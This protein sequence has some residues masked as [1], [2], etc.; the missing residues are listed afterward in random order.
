MWNNFA[1]SAEAIL[2]R[3]ILKRVCKFLLKKKL[4]Q[5]LIGEIDLDQLDVQIAAGTLELT[6]LALNVDFVNQKFGS[7]SLSGAA[8][9]LKCSRIVDMK[10]SW[11]LG[12][13]E[14]GQTSAFRVHEGSIRSLIIK[15]PWNGRGC[16]VEVEELEIVLS[17]CCN[18]GLSNVAGNHDMSGDSHMDHALGKDEHDT[19]YKSS[20]ASVNVHEGVKAVAKL[21]KWLLT[22]FHIRIKNVIVAFDACVE[23]DEEKEVS[24]E[25]LILRITEIECGTCISDD[26]NSTEGTKTEDF[27]GISHLTNFLKF[28][29]ANVELLQMNGVSAENTASGSRF[30]SISKPLLTGE[31]GGFSGSLKLVIP[32]KNGSLDIRKV[33]AEVSIDPLSA[34][35]RPRTLEW[36]LDTW[37]MLEKRKNERIDSVY[38][39]AADTAFCGATYYCYSSALPT[40]MLAAEGLI[41]GEESS[42]ESSVPFSEP[43]MNDVLL[44][45]SRLISD[46]MPSFVGNCGTEGIEDADLGSSVDQFFECFDGMRSFHSALGNSGMWGWTSTVFSAIT[47][48][49]N[50][51]SGSL[52]ISTEQQHVQ[53]NIKITF[54]GV[55]MILSFLDEDQL[56]LHGPPS[57]QVATDANIHHLV[58]SCEDIV[59]SVQVYPHEWKLEA[60]VKHIVLDDY[61]SQED[62]IDFDVCWREK[63]VSTQTLLIEG[64]QDRVLSA[65]PSSSC[66]PGTSN[67]DVSDTSSAAETPS[68][69]LTAETCV[70]RSDIIKA[71][72]FQTSGA[73]MF[74]MS[75]KSSDGGSAGQGSFSLK[76]PAFTFWLNFDLIKV[77][78]DFSRKLGNS[79]GTSNEGTGLLSKATEQK[80]DSSSHCDAIRDQQNHAASTSRTGS[81]H[82]NVYLPHAR[83][84]LCFP[85]KNTGGFKS[86]YSCDQFVA[87]DFS[88]PPN[89]KKSKGEGPALIQED[90]SVKKDYPFISHSL[91]L[92]VVNLDIYLITRASDDCDSPPELSAQRF[93]T[94]KI[95]SVQSGPDWVRLIRMLWQDNAVTGAWVFESAKL[96]ATSDEP[97]NKRSSTT[98]GY[99]FASVST[100]KDLEDLSSQRQREMIYS[101]KF[102]LHVCLSFT[103]VRLSRSQYLCF[104][105]LLNE[106]VDALSAVGSDAHC[107][108][109]GTAVNQTSIFLQCGSVEIQIE[110]DQDD[111]PTSSLQRELPGS[112]YKLRLEIQNLSLLSVSDIGAVNAASFLWISHSEGK[113]WGSISSLGDQDLI[114]ISCS[115]S[116]SGRGNGEGSNVLSCRP[117]GSD[118][119]HLWDPQ[120]LRNCMSITVNCGTIV[121][122]GG[123]LDWLD[124]IST[125][126]SLP[127][128][129]I[130]EGTNCNSQEGDPQEASFVLKFIDAALSYEPY[131]KN[132]E[133]LSSKSGCSVSFYEDLCEPY[134]ACLLAASYLTLSNTTTADTI[135]N[136]YSIRFQDLGLL[137]HAVSKDEGVLVDYSVD[138]L[139]ELGY[140]KVAGEALID[141]VL[142]IKCE[143][144]ISWELTCSESHIVLSTCHDTAFGLIRLA[145]QIQQLFAPDIKDSIVHLQNRWISLQQVQGKDDHKGDSGTSNDCSPLEC[146]AQQPSPDSK[147]KSGLFGLMDEISEYAFKFDGKGASSFDGSGPS[148]SVGGNL[149]DEGPISTAACSGDVLEG[150]SASN[151][152]KAEFIEGY[153][154][155]G[156]RSLSELTM[157]SHFPEDI[158]KLKLV[159]S[160]N[161]DLQRGSGGWY[162]RT[163]LRIVEDYVSDDAVHS[164][165]KQLADVHQNNEEGDGSKKYRG[166]LLLK[167]IGVKW[168]MYAGS[169]WNELGKTVRQSGNISGRDAA[170]CLELALSNMNIQY[171]FFPDGSVC[172]S[173]LCLSVQDFFLYDKSRYAPWKL[174][175]GYYRSREHP[176]ESSSK[177]FKLSLEAVRPDPMT[178]LEEYRLRIACLPVLLHLHQSQL[179]FLIAFFGAKPSPGDWSQ[180]SPQDTCSSGVISGKENDSKIKFDIWPTIVRVDY[181]PSRV[182]LTALSGG[183]Y[184]ELVNLVPWKVINV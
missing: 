11:V 17:P 50:L 21:V 170:V 118:F 183:K 158:P 19:G 78:V 22:S 73:T 45:E 149:H 14:L 4:G 84:I 124:K 34:K 40:A 62:A 35:L 15:M 94:Y 61:L 106:A 148:T 38:H 111:G 82:G 74:A 168:Q 163:S 75:M 39:M 2:S 181:R 80:E 91:H 57:E 115:N 178:P 116:S 67:V 60:I 46:W 145:S 68:S 49:S 122:P 26:K 150:R 153:C 71:T 33:D 103:V 157:N 110:L 147:G 182:D 52:G 25:T 76:L 20:V 53:T 102:C 47:A 79:F 162:G 77:V 8:T 96:L 23:K 141:A 87:F 143:N 5:F 63:G 89:F 99:E 24:H 128:P 139:R 65:L 107:D 64:L 93:C 51:A 9:K 109:S 146:Q 7:L 36:I 120:V 117:A 138:H 165:S 166:R 169:D 164:S 125:F 55:S 113:L 132:S 83:I 159:S 144:D 12:R 18:E 48:A 119:V 58:L 54:L 56:A 180:S 126:V 179:D 135:D 140:A 129:K 134:V 171:D 70:G 88:S 41:Q 98:G 156:L 44:E 184:V 95:L 81:L 175:L 6:D 176:R 155:S 167:N 100:K 43:T 72:V 173:K 127:S 105:R 121:A 16:E 30:H 42:I 114:L 10:W 37:K 161:R 3:F 27:L 85:F 136:A 130:G 160:G 69:L 172:V 133:G 123:R 137:L 101:S 59:V 108:N 152:N 104:F 13:H 92:N 112:W 31:R 66:F 174:V 97:A 86:Y 142:S 131:S 29:G 151:V 28:E 154:L 32:W 90:S 177:A 1:K